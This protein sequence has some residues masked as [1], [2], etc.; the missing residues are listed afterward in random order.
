MLRF[1]NHEARLP[2]GHTVPH[3]PEN[4]TPT[5]TDEQV[6]AARRTV[7][8]YALDAQDAAQLMLALGIF[9]NQDVAN[10]KIPD[11]LRCDWC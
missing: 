6:A 10:F 2:L 5:V 7:A 11:T 3:L 4:V 9:P 1:V 8:Q